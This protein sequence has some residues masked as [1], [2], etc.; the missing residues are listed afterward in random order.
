MVK[1]VEITLDGAVV[2][3]ESC[4][5]RPGESAEPEMFLTLRDLLSGRGPSRS[6]SP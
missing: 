3:E 6:M 2:M 4:A 1:S 5:L